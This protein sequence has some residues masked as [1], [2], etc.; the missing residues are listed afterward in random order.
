[1]PFPISTVGS[2]LF[3]PVAP[4]YTQ[5]PENQTALLGLNILSERDKGRRHE[6]RSNQLQHLGPKNQEAPG[7]KPWLSLDALVLV[8]FL[9]SYSSQYP[10]SKFSFSLR[11]L[12]LVSVA[13]NQE[14]KPEL[15]YNAM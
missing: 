3:P 2:L 13:H 6:Q 15:L 14:L 7:L 10:A 1:M 8:I 9:D 11:H 5:G 12:G 4:W